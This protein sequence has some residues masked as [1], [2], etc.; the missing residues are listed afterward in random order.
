MG[1]E[2]DPLKTVVFRELSRRRADCVAT[3]RCRVEDEAMKRFD[4]YH[5]S[6][7]LVLP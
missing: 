5:P 1:P 6:T 4:R 7:T 3:G 2:S